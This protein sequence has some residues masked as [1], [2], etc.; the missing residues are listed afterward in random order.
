MCY[1]CVCTYSQRNFIK[2]YKISKFYILKLCLCMIIIILR[3]E[4][5]LWKAE[6]ETG[7]ER[8][9]QRLQIYL[10]YFIS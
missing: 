7:L 3:I 8:D 4:F 5:N 2:F 1:L 10:L 9:T 6:R